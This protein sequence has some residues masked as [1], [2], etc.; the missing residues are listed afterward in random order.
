[1]KQSGYHLILSDSSDNVE[2]ENKEISMFVSQMIDG[3]IVAPASRNCDY[4]Q[5]FGEYP[6][7]YIDRVPIQRSSTPIW[8]SRKM[9]SATTRHWTFR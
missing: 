7:V 6:V 3:L 8:L 9:R 5:L 2:A 4:E 1:M